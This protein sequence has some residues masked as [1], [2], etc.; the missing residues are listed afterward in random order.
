A[1]V[2]PT[3]DGDRVRLQT[4]KGNARAYIN[5]GLGFL[6]AAGVVTTAGTLTGSLSASLDTI[7]ILAVL[8]ASMI[9]VSALQLP[10]WARRRREQMEAV[11]GRLALSGSTD[12]PKP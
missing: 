3:A 11:A 1:L 6:G 7:G 10:A 8:G 2:E 4:V 12:E 9:G 5:A